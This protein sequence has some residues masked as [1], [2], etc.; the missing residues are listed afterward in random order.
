VPRFTRRRG[1]AEDEEDD[2]TCTAAAAGAG[3]KGRH[4]DRDEPQDHKRPD[5]GHEALAILW[6]ASIAAALRAARRSPPFVPRYSVS[7]CE[8]M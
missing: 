5:I 8:D 7:P 2:F 3:P 1:D 4:G 6:L